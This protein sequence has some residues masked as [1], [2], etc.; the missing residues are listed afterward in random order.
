MTSIYLIRHCE[1]EGNLFRRAQGHW[2]GRVTERGYVQLAKLIERFSGV[3]LDAVYS[4]D[5]VRARTTAEALARPRGLP[6]HVTER[7][8]E[9]YM[10]VWE[11]KP[12]GQLQHDWPEQMNNF[13]NSP[14]KWHV[15]GGEEFTHVQKRLTGII[16][17][18]AAENEGGTVAI[19]SHGMAIKMFLM[20]VIGNCPGDPDNVGHG[21][22][23]SV[24]LLSVENGN[25]RVLYCNDN[26]HLDEETSTFARQ[27]WWKQAALDPLNFYFVPLDPMDSADAEL[28]KNCYSDTWTAA[29]GSSRGF[30]PSVYLSAA[31]TH[32]KEDPAAIVKVM[33]GNCVAGLIELD[34]GRGVNDGCGWIS[35]FYLRPEYRNKSLG[36]QLIGYA[37][38]YYESR[39]RKMLRLHAAVTNEHAIG[40]YKHYGFREVRTER[41]VSSKQLLMEKTI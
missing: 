6:V 13:N 1:A 22:N 29:H 28:Y 37:S 23:T 3:H 14:D 39:G 9:V 41:G 30:V 25:I 8:R 32:A 16:K 24:S 17:E 21:D 7:L 20:G 4:S 5:L 26:S 15:P 34:P 10:G 38:Y 19:A 18:I 27:R 40:F 35:L 33:S 36:A 31:R 12:W 2:N 11:G